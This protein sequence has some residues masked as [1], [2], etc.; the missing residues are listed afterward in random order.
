MHINR[1]NQEDENGVRI[2]PSL[3][4]SLQLPLL[5][6]VGV[7]FFFF[8][9]LIIC[10]PSSWSFI[11]SPLPSYYR[12]L[13]MMSLS[14]AKTLTG[15]NSLCVQRILDLRSPMRDCVLHGTQL[16]SRWR[17]Q[18]MNEQIMHFPPREFNNLSGS[19]SSSE[20]HQLTLW[21]IKYFWTFNPRKMPF[22]VFNI[23]LQN[24][25]WILKQL[26]ISCINKDMMSTVII[27]NVLSML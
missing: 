22:G 25:C 3:R 19:E 5:L 4:E 26:A 16:N 27:W 1:R 13:Y 10:F 2:S 11:I 20:A 7:F 8:L 6:A 23:K 15:Y 12:R 21:E 9:F 14:C 17:F 24:H 18:I